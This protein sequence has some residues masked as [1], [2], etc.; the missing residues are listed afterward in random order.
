MTQNPYGTPPVR[1]LSQTALIGIVV[2]VVLLIAGGALAAVLVFAG[3][4]DDKDKDSNK[5]DDKTSE[6]AVDVMKGTGYSYT[7]PDNW[8]DISAAAAEGAPGAIDTV[9]VWGEKFEG[10]R[11]N[12]IVES[13]PTSETDLEKLREQW[14]T[15]MTNGTGA[16]PERI[17]GTT[18]G[19]EDAIGTRI[20]RTNEKGVAILQTA[21]L[22]VR[23]G[24]IYSI[25]LSGRSGDD[26]AVAAFEAI[27][28]SWNW[29]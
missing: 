24:K 6:P 13:G 29:E 21:Y 26:E 1:K 9:A 15:N 22:V 2:V 17:E 20:E 12:V 7:L 16:T 4:D 11:A 19:G 27:Q 10:G 23:D 28:D 14:A 8:T 3:S 18:I 25:A 5:A